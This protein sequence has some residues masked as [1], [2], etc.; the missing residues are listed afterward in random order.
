M[1]K[2]GLIEVKIVR[3]KVGYLVKI[4]FKSFSQ[5]KEKEYF[6]LAVVDD[7]GSYTWLQL[8]RKILDHDLP[9]KPA[10]LQIHFLVKF[11]IESIC[12]LAENKTIELFY[13]QARSLIFRGSLEV[14]A[15]I[16]F[17]LA[18][19]SLQA[20]YGD[21]VDDTTTRGL[22]RK[23]PI[24]P[25]HIMKDHIGS[26]EDQV[27]GHYVKVKNNIQGVLGKKTH[28]DFCFQTK[29][30]TRGQAI[31]NYM[32]IVESMPTYGV[33]YFEVLDKRGSLWWLGLSCRG[34]AQYEA[35]DRRTPVRVFQWKQ[36][37]NLYFRDK[38]FSIEVHD[39]KRVVQTLSSFNLYEDVN[40]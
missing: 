32:T 29:G 12:H 26:C 40:R 1:R 35:N 14:E 36:L 39:A 7:N 33:H 2:I 17:Q 11:F 13:L 6:G 3:Q 8:D 28:H 31:V 23:S 22:I 20:S 21:H 19:L 15:D 4:N 25:S 9:R 38:K 10:T 24:L 18:A 27:I 30:Q 34:I 37:E 16:V 5:L